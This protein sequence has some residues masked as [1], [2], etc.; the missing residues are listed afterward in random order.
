MQFFGEE[1][2]LEIA[3][4]LFLLDFEDALEGFVLFE[5]EVHGFVVG[6]FKLV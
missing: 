1:L 2:A 3:L 6:F 5:G 4:E